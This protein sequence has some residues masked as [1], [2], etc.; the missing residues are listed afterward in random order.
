MMFLFKFCPHSVSF[1]SPRWQS[2]F[3]GA[4][5]FFFFVFRLLVTS[6]SGSA[7]P[8]G[9]LICL[10]LNPGWHLVALCDIRVKR[11]K[12]WNVSAPFLSA[13]VFSVS[14]RKFNRGTD[15]FVDI[16]C[17]ARQSSC[18]VRACHHEAK[19]HRQLEQKIKLNMFHLP[20]C[21]TSEF[22]PVLDARLF[23][24]QRRLKKEEIF[25]S[26]F[27]SVFFCCFS[28]KYCVCQY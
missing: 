11:Q 17:L 10:Y 7:L 27:V 21:F 6:R 12:P 25:L 19:E 23:I 28:P 20:S 26:Y 16:F 5:V 14:W 24:L 15:V 4:Y 8:F 2:H 3:C 13:A 9:W 22:P 18:A 1:I